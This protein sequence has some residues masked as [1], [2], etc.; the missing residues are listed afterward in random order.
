MHYRFFDK[1]L[2]EEFMYMRS[3]RNSNKYNYTGLIILYRIN[4]NTISCMRI[5]KLLSLR[6]LINL[7]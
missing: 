5:E 3:W 1:R 7:T 4:F 6:L 2:K